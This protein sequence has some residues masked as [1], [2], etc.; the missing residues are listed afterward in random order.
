MTGWKERSSVM[1]D[2]VKF[3]RV[4]VEILNSNA[5]TKISFLAKL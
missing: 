4:T 1:N 3:K 2:L 5:Q